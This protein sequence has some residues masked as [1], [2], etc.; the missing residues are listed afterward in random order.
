MSWNKRNNRNSMHG[1]TIKIVVKLP[2]FSGCRTVKQFCSS[3]KW[4]LLV[5]R[6]TVTYSDKVIGMPK[7]VYWPYTN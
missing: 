2:K 6:S 3:M 1:G 7:H 4:Y 5:P